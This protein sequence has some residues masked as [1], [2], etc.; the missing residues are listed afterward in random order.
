L[1]SLRFGA[2]SLWLS[3][4]KK[5][6]LVLL[7]ID[8]DVDVDIDVDEDVNAPTVSDLVLW[9]SKFLQAELVATER[10][11]DNIILLQCNE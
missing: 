2:K 7:V 1:I 9:E 4:L 10:N 6:V 11:R 5:R 3:S 8:V